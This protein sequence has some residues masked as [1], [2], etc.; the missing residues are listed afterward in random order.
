MDAKL[1][2]KVGLLYR[3]L[4]GWTT[5]EVVAA[6][7][8]VPVGVV[9]RAADQL[10]AAGYLEYGE[11]NRRWRIEREFEDLWNELVPNRPCQISFCRSVRAR[12]SQRSRS[13]A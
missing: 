9:V 13:L 2:L 5:A 12:G 4:E 1:T 11:Q 6:R 10:E 8:S 7:L 3:I